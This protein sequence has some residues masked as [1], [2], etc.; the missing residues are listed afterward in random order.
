MGIMNA[1]KER[2][3]TNVKSSETIALRITT[4]DK[5]GQTSSAWV[6]I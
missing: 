6:D 5:P 1:A 4:R 2:V 3:R